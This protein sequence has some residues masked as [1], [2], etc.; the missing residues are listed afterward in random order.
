VKISPTHLYLQDRT[1]PRSP[2]GRPTRGRQHVPPH[3]PLQRGRRR[4]QADRLEIDRTRTGLQEGPTESEFRDTETPTDRVLRPTKDAAV[5]PGR[6]AATAGC[7]TQEGSVRSMER[8]K[9]RTGNVCNQS[10]TGGP[11]SKVVV[12][13]CGVVVRASD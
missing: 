8:G 9:T 12:L 1:P 3:S 6:R 2:G 4:Y 7:D 11:N 13:F 5:V 10:T